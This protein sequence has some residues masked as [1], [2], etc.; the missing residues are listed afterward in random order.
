MAAV[1]QPQAQ[2]KPAPFGNP[3]RPSPLVQ[4]MAPEHALLWDSFRNIDP[5]KEAK[6]LQ[7]RC[8][9]LHMPSC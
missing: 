8:Q 3:A 6:V 9:G 1:C 5:E 4:V 7:V 2:F